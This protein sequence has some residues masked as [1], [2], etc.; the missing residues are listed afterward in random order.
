M[1]CSVVCVNK[2][3]GW[4]FGLPYLVKSPNWELQQLV[5]LN[6]E[7]WCL[8]NTAQDSQQSETA[9]QSNSLQATGCERKTVH[10]HM[11]VCVCVSELRVHLMKKAW[12]AANC[13]NVSSAVWWNAL[14]MHER[15]YVCWFKSYKDTVTGVLDGMHYPCIW[16]CVWGGG[17]FLIKPIAI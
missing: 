6:P 1:F 11:C 9:R 5:S 2:T 4:G 12:S 17:L 10:I 14:S 16:V 13:I 8:L 7:V 15:M 3:A